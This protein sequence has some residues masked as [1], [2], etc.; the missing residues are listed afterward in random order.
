QDVTALPLDLTTLQNLI[1]GNPVF[2]DSTIVSYSLSNNTISMLS[3]GQWFKNLLTLD[4]QDKT[5][6]HSKLDDVDFAHSRTA[7]L[8]YSDYDDKKGVPFSTRRRIAVTEKN[9]LDIRMDFKQYEFNQE[10][11]FPFTI[12]K[13]YDRD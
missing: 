13:N 5:L 1:I 3:V 10:V 8:T 11:S 4:A 7:D 2:V 9:H 12:P 6:L